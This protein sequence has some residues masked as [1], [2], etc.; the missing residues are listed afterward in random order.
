MANQSFSS[1]NRAEVYN[2]LTREELDLLVV[3][4]GITGAG[5]ALDAASPCQRNAR[6]RQHRHSIS[7]NTSNTYQQ[8]NAQHSSL[9]SNEAMSKQSANS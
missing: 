6:S 9:R 5:I 2:R 8:R 4:G 3:G 7:G 1:K